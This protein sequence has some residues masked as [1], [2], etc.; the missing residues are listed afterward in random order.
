VSGDNSWTGTIV[1]NS[2]AT[3]I[4]S[5][6]GVLDIVGVIS[7]SGSAGVRYGGVGTVKLSGVSTYTGVTEISPGATLLL[8]NNNVLSSSSNVRFGGGKLLSDGKS[9]S[10]GTLSVSSSSELVL[11]TGSHAVRFSGAGTFSFTRL[12]IKGWEGVYAGSGT[13]GTAGQV[14]VGNAGGVLSREQLDQIQFVDSNNVSYY[15][16]QLGTGEVVPGVGTLSN[17]TGHS[18][19]QVTT[20]ATS[21]GSWTVSGSGTLTVHTF[22]PSADNANILAS[23]ITSRLQGATGI[24]KGSV[25]IVTTNAGVGTQ[26][27]NVKFCSG[28]ECE[29]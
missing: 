12:V 22:T 24:T 8:G 28:I 15:A 18:N 1:V 9:V 5:D 3:G 23:E 11:G 16:V 20:S 14:F 17:P 27:G 4:S 10:A 13:S 25:R 21:G 7:G 26:V 19:V 29:Q 6:S 2:A